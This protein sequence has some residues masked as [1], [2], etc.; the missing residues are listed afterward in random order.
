[1]S[2]PPGGTVT[3]IYDG[4]C[5]F[6]RA[7]RDWLD[8]RVCVTWIPAAQWPE[9]QSGITAGELAASLHALRRDGRAASGAAAIAWALGTAPRRR[10][11]F[12][13]RALTLPGVAGAAQVAY[14]VVARHRGQLSRFV[15][16]YRREAA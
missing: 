12:A 13:A 8:S 14:G 6:C 16:W 7:C 9:G 11:R 4:R 10:W 15:R 1:V 2:T 3:V 5:R